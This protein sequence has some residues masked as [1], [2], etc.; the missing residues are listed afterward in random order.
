MGNSLHLDELELR[1]MPL[2]LPSLVGQTESMMYLR[3]GAV[4]VR[5]QVD[6]LAQAVELLLANNAMA[7]PI[8]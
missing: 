2:F 8:H 1:L 6:S 4:G 5:L 7:L 3:T